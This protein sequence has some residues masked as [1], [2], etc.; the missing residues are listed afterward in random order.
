MTR[1]RRLKA[2]DRRAL[3]LGLLLVTPVAGYRVVVAPWLADTAE[4][5]ASLA[6]ERS[7]LARELAVVDGAAALPA[8]AADLQTELDG[9]RPWLLDAATALAASGA[10]SRDVAA[11]AEDAGILIQEVQG[12]DGGEDVGAV[13]AS[14]LAVRALGDLEGILRFLHA[15]ENEP[16]LLTVGELSLRTAGVNDGDLEQGQLMSLALVV[17]GYW[18]EGEAPSAGPVRAVSRTGGP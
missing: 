18:M 13:H 4:L 2:R 8:A 9:V 6:A 10:L 15:L 16:T 5:R 3:V 7:L 12:R 1:R 11:H 17:S 14:S